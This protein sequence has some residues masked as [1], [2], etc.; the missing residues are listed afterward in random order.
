MSSEKIS[1]K[2]KCTKKAKLLKVMLNVCRQV[3]GFEEKKSIVI[4]ENY[5]NAL[6]NFKNSEIKLMKNTAHLT[7]SFSQM[8]I[9][10][11]KDIMEGNFKFLLKGKIKIMN[12][13]DKTAFI[14]LSD[15]YETLDIEKD[16]DAKNYIEFAIIEM[17]ELLV[18]D[19]FDK[20]K[21][22]YNFTTEDLNRQ[23]D[24]KDEDVS[25]VAT[26]VFQTA[27]KMFGSNNDGKQKSTKDIAKTMLGCDE[28]MTQIERFSKA[29]QKNPGAIQELASKLATQKK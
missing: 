27:F 19:N 25:K 1:E 17:L 14:P 21:S 22:R 13:E 24:D 5:V 12:S 2:E 7:S 28:M 4:F 8:F 20:V 6:E 15:I 18:D 3:E 10:N 16:D 11:K 23:V 9:E 29:T 26:D